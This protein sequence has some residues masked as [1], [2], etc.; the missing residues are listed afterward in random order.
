MWEG[1]NGK[2][3]RKQAQQAKMARLM[4]SKLRIKKK[5]KNVKNK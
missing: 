4:A 3:M 2:G 1:E 5:L